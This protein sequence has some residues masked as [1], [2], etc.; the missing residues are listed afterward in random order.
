MDGGG[1]VRLRRQRTSQG[2]G[3]NLWPKVWRMI[4]IFASFLGDLASRCVLKAL[5]YQTFSHNFKL[6][7]GK[8]KRGRETTGVLPP[9]LS[10]GRRF[11]QSDLAVTHNFAEEYKLVKLGRN[12]NVAH[13]MIHP[14]TV[15]FTDRRR[16]SAGQNRE[17]YP[18]T[19][20]RVCSGVIAGEENQLEVSRF[21]SVK[22]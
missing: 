17:C 22:S 4:G 12:V 10:Q 2:Q 3:L 6:C 9:G 16:P 21:L 8:R 19:A 15:S 7:L 14:V 11:R 1:R 5:T 13:I 20:R 18:A